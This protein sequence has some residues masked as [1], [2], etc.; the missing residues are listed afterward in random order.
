MGF[1]RLPRH[2]RARRRRV[3]VGLAERDRR[4]AEQRALDGAGDGAG[5]GDVVGDVLARIDAGEHEVGLLV[6]EQPAHRHDDAVGRRAA[7]GEAPLARSRAGAAD[8]SATANATGRSGRVSGATTQTSSESVRGD[9]LQRREP[10]RVDAVVVGEEDAHQS[11]DLLHAAH[12][13]LQ[14]PPARRSSRPRSG[15][16]PS[17]RS[18]RGRRRRPSRSACG[19]GACPCRPFG[20]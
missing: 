1:R 11:A 7:E 16:S 3:G 4:D 5:I 2:D 8:R 13:R 15:S 9:A 10:G 12:V 14:R 17:P 20:R 19:R 6:G 18:A